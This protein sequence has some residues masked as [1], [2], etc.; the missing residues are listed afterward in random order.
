MQ[1]GAPDSVVSIHPE[2]HPQKHLRSPVGTTILTAI[3][4]SS[5]IGTASVGLGHLD[6]DHLS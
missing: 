4:T 1:T 6:S 3:A 2:C 5:V